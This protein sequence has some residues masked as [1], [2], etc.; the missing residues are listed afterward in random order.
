MREENGKPNLFLSNLNADLTASKLTVNQ[1]SLGE[2]S[3]VAKTAASKLTFN[4][5]SNIASSQ[6]HGSGESKLTGEYP[7][8][9]RIAFSNI[10]YSKLAPFIGSETT[11]PEGFDALV[12]GQASVNGPLLDTDS[13]SA[14]LQLDRLDV[15]TTPRGTPTGGPPT[16]TVDFQNDGPLVVSLDHSTVR[17]NQFKIHGPKTN[18][19][20]S[21]AINL[22]NSQAPLRL[23]VEADADLGVLQDISRDFYSSGNVAMNATVRGTFSQPLVNGS[24]ELKNANINY[25]DTSNGL[26]N[27]NGVILLNGNTA[28]IQSLTGESGGGKIIVS[29][30]AGLTN[31]VLSFNLRAAA[32]KVRTRYSGISVVSNAN[33]VLVGNTRHSRLGGAVTIQRIAYSSSSDAGSILS[34]ASTPPVTPTAPSPLLANMRL[35]IRI[36]TAPDVRV[37]TTYADR[38][39]VYA[40]LTVRGTASSPG[41]LGRVNVTDGQLVFFGNT[42]EVNN[43]A[44]NFYDPN[45]IQP[46]LNVSLET[47]AQG[48]DVVINVSGPMDDLKLTYRSDPPLSF[49][50]IVQL[51]ATNTT[52]SD[53]T[54]AAHQ[55]TPPQ[56]SL[57]QMGESALLG[58]A[59][60]N[61]L[62]SRVQRVFGLTQF[63]IDPSFS[64][65]NGQPSARVTLQ[66]KIA[67]NV[68][69]TYITDVTQTNSEIVRVEWDL[70]PKF[71]VVALRDFNGNVSV[72]FFYKFKM[73]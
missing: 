3:F 4:L 21:G 19:V 6:V 15:K 43:G 51:L 33:I 13:L 1:R 63:K 8:R 35:D 66:Q 2:V 29:G 60:A 68:T 23:N 18:L 32:S 44:I 57:G 28:T 24:I 61:P 41:I 72:E 56:Q 7:T 31:S 64:G 5:D 73:R 65:S 70:T 67:S 49:E 17:V 34:T 71:S 12:E 40:S 46:V 62:A 30:F 25:A 16:E 20:V 36:A 11:P 27:G 39:D 37:V 47:I 22:K 42:Y 54:I 10:R 48:V 53:P 45:A 38:L 55:P 52:P 26:S 50:Q 59:V 9:A 69:F 58:Q 14:R